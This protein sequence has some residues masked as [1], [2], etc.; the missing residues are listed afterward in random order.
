MQFTFNINDNLF[1][2]LY[3]YIILVHT[4][5]ENATKTILINVCEDIR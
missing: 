5:N 2:V 3:I 1:I 4:V